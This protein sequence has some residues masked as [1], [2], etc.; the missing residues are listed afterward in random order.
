[1]STFNEARDVMLTVLMGA[2]AT[3]EN[4][5]LH[6]EFNDVKPLDQAGGK[7]WGR[8][9]IRHSNGQQSS[10]TGPFEELKR[11]TNSG[12]VFIQL[13]A[14]LGDGSETLYDMAQTLVD[15]YRASRHPNVWF[16]NVQINEVGT[17]G[18]WEGINVLADFEYDQ[19]RK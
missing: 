9:T 15:A 14:P 2:W 5:T 19:Q 12:R 11:Y 10:L 8:A 13:F 18:P 4:G 16:R 3:F 6:L 1:M 17:R 7:P